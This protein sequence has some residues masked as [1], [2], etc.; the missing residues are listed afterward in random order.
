[1]ISR[2]ATAV[3]YARFTRYH[4][5]DSFE[6]VG[7]FPLAFV[8]EALVTFASRRAEAVASPRGDLAAA[9]TLQHR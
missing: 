1:M 8:L 5:S 6:H 9:S 4:P 7:P 3:E 2:V